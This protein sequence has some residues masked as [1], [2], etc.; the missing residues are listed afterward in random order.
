[1]PT[2]AALAYL[3][4]VP[5]PSTTGGANP[6][7]GYCS[8]ELGGSSTFGGI[9]ASGVGWVAKSDPD[10]VVVALCVFPDLSFIF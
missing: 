5:M 1:M 3:S 8:R 9:S 4:K 7:T 10:D 2:L 6:A